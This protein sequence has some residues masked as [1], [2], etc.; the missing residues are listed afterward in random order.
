MEFLLIVY[1][2]VI[3]PEEGEKNIELKMPYSTKSKCIKASKKLGWE[4]KISLEEL[5]NE[6]VDNDLREAKKEKMI[7]QFTIR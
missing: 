6:M 7:N 2:T 4:P 3:S 5:V 1:L